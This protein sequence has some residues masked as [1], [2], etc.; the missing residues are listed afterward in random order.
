MASPRVTYERPH[1]GLLGLYALAEMDRVGPVHGYY[2]SERIA[3]RTEGAWRP[4]PGAVYPALTKLTSRKLAHSERKGR[5]RLYSITPQ[6]RALLARIRSRNTP[7][8]TRA[9][10]LTVLWADVMGVEDV[11]TYLLLRLRRSLD[12]ISSALASPPRG[13]AMTPG[14]KSLRDDVVAE[15]T[16]RLEQLRR[17]GVPLVRPLVR[18]M[19]GGAT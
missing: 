12:G 16:V 11:A 8:S 2:L 3:E 4:G 1:D 13:V 10:D 7:W 6:G 14:L 19:A 9:P 18:R 17:S 5:R 15:L